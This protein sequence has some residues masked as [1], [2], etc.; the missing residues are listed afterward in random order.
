MEDTV[1][2]LDKYIGEDVIGLPDEEDE[3]E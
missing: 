1:V 3:D 2:H